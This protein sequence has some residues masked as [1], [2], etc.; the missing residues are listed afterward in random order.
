[1]PSPFAVQ[2]QHPVVTISLMTDWKW[3]HYSHSSPCL[4]KHT[5]H[6]R[7]RS[8]SVIVSLRFTTLFFSFSFLQD[9]SLT[10]KTENRTVIVPKV[11]KST[12]EFKTCA[13]D[14]NNCRRGK[15]YNCH[16]FVDLMTSEH[17]AIAFNCFLN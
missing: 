12:C 7:A 16:H 2:S 1:M 4:I 14:N 3:E 11:E 6:C 13:G 17:R 15:K 9:P 8:S 10:V 5:S